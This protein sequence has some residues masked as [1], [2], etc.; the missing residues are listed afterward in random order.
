MPVEIDIAHVA[1]L[2]RLDLSE[3]DLQGYKAQLA[4]ILEHAARVQ[5][6]EGEPEV[7]AS[8]PLRFENAY[9]EDEPRPSLDRDEVLSQAPDSRD[10]YFVVPPAMEID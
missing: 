10:G 1:R 6:L 2:A 7:E 8:H 3:G 5:S 4:N 9:R